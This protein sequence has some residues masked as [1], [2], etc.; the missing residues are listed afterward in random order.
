MNSNNVEN[1]ENVENIVKIKKRGRPAITDPSLKKNKVRR[2]KVGRPK[3]FIEIE[4][5][6]TLSQQRY[7]DR[8]FYSHKSYY[9]IKNNDGII[10]NELINLPTD[11]D[12]QVKEQYYL[13]K[14]FIENYK[15]EK[16]IETSTNNLYKPRQLKM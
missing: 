2:E 16:E 9:F 7:R 3:K 5:G 1:V 4:N 6:L 15:I 14:K 10:P 12:N 11:T 13:I 8:H